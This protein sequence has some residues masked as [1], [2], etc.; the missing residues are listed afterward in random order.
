LVFQ[1]K[2]LR[3]NAKW[4]V[5]VGDVVYLMEKDDDDKFCRMGIV[6]EVKE[7]QE[8]NVRTA[9]VKYTNPGGG[10]PQLLALKMAIHPI[11]KLAVIHANVYRLVLDKVFKGRLHITIIFVILVVIK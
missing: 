2:L 7:G 6:E 8:G 4:N 5:V 9:T 10:S 1:E 11:H 3:R